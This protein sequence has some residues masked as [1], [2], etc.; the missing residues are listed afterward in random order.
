[1]LFNQNKLQQSLHNRNFKFMIYQS[2]L[3][4][5]IPFQ[6]VVAMDI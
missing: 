2:H 1:M 5:C 4:L 3:E 6:I